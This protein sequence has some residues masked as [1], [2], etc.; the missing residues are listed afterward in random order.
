MN[1]MDS[2]KCGTCVLAGLSGDAGDLVVLPGPL[3]LIFASPFHY[4]GAFHTKE[5]T[6]PQRYVWVA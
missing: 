5:V 3:Y 2:V 4:S 1:S 6:R